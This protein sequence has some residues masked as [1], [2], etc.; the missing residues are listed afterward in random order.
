MVGP[1]DKESVNMAVDLAKACAPVAGESL[2]DRPEVVA[3]FIET[4]AAK[5]EV[6]KFGP[7]RP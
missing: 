6:L 4:V 2:I 7:T 1:L 5:I 3:A